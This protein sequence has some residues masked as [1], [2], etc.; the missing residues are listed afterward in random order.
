MTVTAAL[1]ADRPFPWD[2]EVAL[3]FAGT[4]SSPEDYSGTTTTVVI[5]A[6]RFT[7]TGIVSIMPVDNARLDGSRTI[8]YRGQ[9]RWHPQHQPRPPSP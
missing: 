9:R 7:G 4:A 6:N 1:S 2:T 8:D 3:S 5:P